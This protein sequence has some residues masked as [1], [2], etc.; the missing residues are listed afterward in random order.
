MHHVTCLIIDVAFVR[1]LGAGSV[2]AAESVFHAP[3]VV[4]A[5]ALVAPV[6]AGLVATVAHQISF[7]TF[8]IQ[9]LELA[10]WT[11]VGVS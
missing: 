1:C 5:E 3:A 10:L 8:A 9:A 7:N 4:A 6:L 2:V 11:A